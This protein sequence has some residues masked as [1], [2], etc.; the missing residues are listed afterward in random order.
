MTKE[1]QE[2]TMKC[3]NKCHTFYTT[4]D[5]PAHEALDACNN[6]SCICH[7]PCDNECHFQKSYGFVPEA[8][9]EVHDIPN[10]E[11]EGKVI[12]VVVE[13]KSDLF[14]V[15]KRTIGKLKQNDE[16]GFEW[17]GKHFIIKKGEFK[18]N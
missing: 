16:L 1:E 9:C 3:C 8:G 13:K 6:R 5:Y 17:N 10:K 18:S 14:P 12:E 15:I 2:N 4:D 7:Q 11:P